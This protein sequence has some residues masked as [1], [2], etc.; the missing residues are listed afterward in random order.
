[1]DRLAKIDSNSYVLTTT[2]RNKPDWF[3]INIHNGEEYKQVKKVI[4]ENKLHTVCE[5]ARCPNRN[6][7]WNKGTATFLI[8]GRI[9]TRAC[10]FCGV[11]NGNPRQNIDADEPF[12]IAKAVKA[13]KLKH[14]VITSV[15][16]D[17]LPDGGAT[18]FA[19]TIQSIRKYIQDC[20][21]EVLI[22]DFSGNENS[23]DI[24]LDAR[25][26]IL[27]HNIETVPRLYPLVRAK[28]SYERSLMILRKASRAGFITKSGLMVGLGEKREELIDAMKDL[29]N[30]G[31]HI[32]TIGQYLQP[33]S[34]KMPVEHYYSPEDFN[35]LKAIGMEMGFRYVESG[36][37]VRSSY[38]APKH[39]EKL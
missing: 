24:V 20:S 5:E 37:F 1:M 39:F 13:L 7:C 35:Y 27:N 34:G 17:D 2:Y 15:T 36:P 22:P 28:A 30:A 16:R 3:K 23:I 32:L 29:R 33:K 31:C 8:L 25:P 4:L 11:E 9:C 26:D 19:L 10:R 21:I 18:Y 38:N 14:A 6:E 12:R